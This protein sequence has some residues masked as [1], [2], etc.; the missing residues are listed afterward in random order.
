MRCHRAFDRL[1]R[2]EEVLAE[3]GEHVGHDFEGGEVVVDQVVLVL[4]VGAAEGRD[5][6]P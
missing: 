3:V 6:V 4:P 2:E 5:A 1:D